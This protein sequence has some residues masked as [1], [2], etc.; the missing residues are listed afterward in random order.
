MCI[1]SAKLGSQGLIFSLEGGER[2]RFKSD[3]EVITR[4]MTRESRCGG[5]RQGD[6]KTVTTPPV[7]VAQT[8]HGMRSERTTG[9]N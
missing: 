3:F 5:P 4:Y 9:E 2:T 1:P 7:K 6:K 8:H